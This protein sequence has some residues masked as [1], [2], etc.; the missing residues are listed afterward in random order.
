MLH[1][2]VSLFIV[3]IQAQFVADSNKNDEKYKF[4]L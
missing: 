3:V 2:Q 1:Q 4:K